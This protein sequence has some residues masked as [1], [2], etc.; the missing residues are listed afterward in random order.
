MHRFGALHCAD[1]SRPSQGFPVLISGVLQGAWPIGLTNGLYHSCW[2][3]P[4][5][6][7]T[8]SITHESSLTMY[9]LIP[10]IYIYIY[11][12]C[13]EFKLRPARES[14][15]SVIIVSSTWPDVET[16]N[17]RDSCPARVQVIAIQIEFWPPLAFSW[18]PP[19]GWLFLIYSMLVV[20]V[21]PMILDVLSD[22]GSAWIFP[23]GSSLDSKVPQDDWCQIL[24][25]L[26]G[27]K[28]WRF[29][30]E[31]PKVRQKRWS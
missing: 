9:F 1:L 10:Y 15:S 16:S 24:N 13:L 2:G 7:E 30:R 5:T 4:I 12:V 25:V 20:A 18:N 22:A 29:S 28:S 26:Q 14:P 8:H 17:Q 27:C 6:M 23:A 3:I 19:M 31:A 11:C 21:T